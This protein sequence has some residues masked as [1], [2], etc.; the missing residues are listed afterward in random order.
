LVLSGRS[1]ASH[2]RTD[3]APEPMG[4]GLLTPMPEGAQSQVICA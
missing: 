2:S 3:A 4:Q 1:W